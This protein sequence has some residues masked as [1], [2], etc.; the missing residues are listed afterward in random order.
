MTTQPT[1][2]ATQV[3]QT[4]AGAAQRRRRWRPPRVQELGLLV[5]VLVLGTILS[6]YGHFDARG[7]PNTFLNLDNL[8]GQIATYMAVY[9]IMAVGVTCVIITGGIDISVG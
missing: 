2:T 8:V 4:P 9:A 3:A 6:I 1:T 7:G 5:V